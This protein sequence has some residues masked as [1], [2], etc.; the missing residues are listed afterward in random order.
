MSY[1][2]LSMLK[3]CLNVN[4]TNVNQQQIGTNIENTETM[5]QQITQTMS[6]EAR[7]CKM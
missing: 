1:E 6:P 5:S 4:T 3:T 7:Y 2:K